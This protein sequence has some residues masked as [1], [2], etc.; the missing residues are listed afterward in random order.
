MQ[1]MPRDTRTAFETALGDT[2]IQVVSLGENLPSYTTLHYQLQLAL[3]ERDKARA[4][5]VELRVALKNMINGIVALEG[6]PIEYG[7]ALGLAEALKQSRA[8]LAKMDAEKQ[9]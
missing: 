8:L 1:T 9:P 4:D 2:P 7:I 5:V 3:A 6:T